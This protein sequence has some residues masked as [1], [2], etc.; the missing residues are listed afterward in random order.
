MLLISSPPITR[1]IL[2]QT[3]RPTHSTRIRRQSDNSCINIKCLI[4]KLTS[5]WDFL[6]TRRWRLT[7]WASSF[8]NII[9]TR[10]VILTSRWSSRRIISTT[11]KFEMKGNLLQKSNRKAGKGE[12]FL[13][14]CP[15]KN[16]VW[17]YHEFSRR[18]LM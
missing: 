4:E 12:G 1:D 6:T 11:L 13:G 9:L 5:H 14:R 7:G 2:R 8:K 3:G 16:H 15:E 10:N 18:C 17:K